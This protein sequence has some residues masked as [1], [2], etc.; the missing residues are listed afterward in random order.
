MK[1]VLSKFSILSFLSIISFIVAPPVFSYPF[2]CVNDNSVYEIS[3]NEDGQWA[4]V[5]YKNIPNRYQLSCR[6][7]STQNPFMQCIG[8]GAIYIFDT[9][10]SYDTVDSKSIVVNLYSR[11]IG[12][13]WARRFI[14]K[15]QCF[16]SALKT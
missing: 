8:E 15:F 3:V 6:N 16:D 14:S 4:S 7:L 9:E 13:N 12:D 5:R 11:H 10:F 1:S 2:S